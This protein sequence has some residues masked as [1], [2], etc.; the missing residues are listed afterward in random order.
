M[1]TTRPYQRRRLVVNRA[2]QFRFVRAMLV[3]LVVMALAA[4]VAVFVAIRITLSTFELSQDAVVVSLFNVICW[5]IVLELLIVTPAVIWLGILLTHKIAGP[6][7]RIG[8]ALAQ[9][10][11]G[12]YNIHIQLRR[13]DEL[14][15]VAA[16]VNHL[17]ATLRSRRS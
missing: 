2:L 16:L 10:A 17:A 5:L 1:T 6:L 12:D 4:V 9:M 14:R 3:I 11:E 15:E 8:A 13:G 7:V